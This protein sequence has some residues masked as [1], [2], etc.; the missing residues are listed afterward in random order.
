ML[1]TCTIKLILHN[2]FPFNYDKAV[3]DQK[4]SKPVAPQVPPKKPV[5]PN[6]A[7]SILRAGNLHPKWPD[8][9][10]PK[11]VFIFLIWLPALLGIGGYD[12]VGITKTWWDERQIWN[13]KMEGYHLFRKDRKGKRDGGVTL[14]VREGIGC[15]EIECS[16][17]GDSVEAVWVKLRGF[18]R[19][20]DQT[21]GGCYRPPGQ[22]ETLDDVLT[23]QIL[24]ISWGRDTV[25]MGDFNLPDISWE[26]HSA[27]TV[28]SHH[29]IEAIEGGF[30]AQRVREAMTG[31]GGNILDLVL[32]NTEE[33]IDEVQIRG[34]LDASDHSIPCFEIGNGDVPQV[35]H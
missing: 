5:P 8:K 9:P 35:E 4:T 11:Q 28:W 23:D 29:F 27:V 12:L 34:A 25:I 15:S 31:G 18:D 32:T 24:R 14:Y 22:L 7:N 30:F 10:V 19:E 17:E 6:K 26:N 33:L 20:R 1:T 16:T 3:L 2:F 13:V 21:V